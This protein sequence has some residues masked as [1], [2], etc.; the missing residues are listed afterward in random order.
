MPGVFGVLGLP[1]AQVDQ[2]LDRIHAMTGAQ[3]RNCEHKGALADTQAP[4]RGQQGR[5]LPK[6]PAR[7]F[8]WL[9]GD[10]T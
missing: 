10:S 9:P 7:Y 8:E 5:S 3:T 2:M 1:N 6:W 4:R